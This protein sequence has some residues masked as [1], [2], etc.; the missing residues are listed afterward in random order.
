MAL[1]ALR[2][3]QPE[4]MGVR[5][6]IVVLPNTMVI[7]WRSFV[8]LIIVLLFVYL[9]FIVGCTTMYPVI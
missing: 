1:C 4:E 9:P 2:L 6:T 8:S 7:V 3:D 5:S